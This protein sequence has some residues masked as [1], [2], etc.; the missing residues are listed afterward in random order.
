VAVNQKTPKILPKLLRKIFKNQW[1]KM[2]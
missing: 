1:K 2:S